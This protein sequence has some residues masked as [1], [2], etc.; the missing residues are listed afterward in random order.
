MTYAGIRWWPRRSTWSPDRG[1]GRGFESRRPL[2]VLAATGKSTANVLDRS[3]CTLTPSLPILKATTEKP[4]IGH[5]RDRMPGV[6][7]ICE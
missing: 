7:R 4:R 2:R 5:A 1:K 3:R 6:G